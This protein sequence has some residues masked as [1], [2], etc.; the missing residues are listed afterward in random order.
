[1]N[2]NMWYWWNDSARKTEVLGDK[3]DLMPYYLPKIQLGMDWVQ[4]CPLE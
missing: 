2:M 4:T 3:L 1:M